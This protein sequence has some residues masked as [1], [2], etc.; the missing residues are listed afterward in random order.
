M[1]Y[2]VI[3]RTPINDEV[4]TDIRIFDDIN[5]AEYYKW[6]YSS[7]YYQAHLYEASRLS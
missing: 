4:V 5:A 2:I 7:E 6:K 3:I 1:C